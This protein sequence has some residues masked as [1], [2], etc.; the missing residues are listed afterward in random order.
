MKTLVSCFTYL[1][2]FQGLFQT[3]N[4]D[5]MEPDSLRM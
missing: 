4:S 5:D 2:N 3:F 1:N